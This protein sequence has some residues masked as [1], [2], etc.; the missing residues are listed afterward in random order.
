MVV[1]RRAA[2]QALAAGISLADDLA[3]WSLAGGRP[4]VAA[5]PG[6][7]DELGALLEAATGDA[8]RRRQ[9]AHYTPPA[10]AAELVAKAVGN[11]PAP[12]V[13]DPACGGGALLLAVARHLAAAGEAPADVLARLWGIDVDPVA[14]ATTEVALA[15]WAGTSPPPGH[16]VVG[17]G[18]LGDLAWPPVDVIVGNPPFLSQLGAA[19]AHR[20]VDRRR[21]RDH[22]G[23]AAL[24]YTDVAG[25]FLARACELVVPG[26]VVA[27]LQPQS[28]LGARDAAGVRAAVSA[29]G[30]VVDVWFPPPRAFAAAVE[31]CVPIVGVG[32]P[33][34]TAEW[35]PWLARAHGVPEVDLA[36]AGCLADEAT[37]TA[38][39]RGEYYGLVEQLHEAADLP[40]GRPIVTA[41][42]VDLGGCAWGERPARLGRRTWD[43]PVVDV[44]ALSGRAAAWVER[45]GVPKLVVASQTSVL[46]VA[47]DEHGAWI[48][49]VP[50][51]AVLAPPARLW[52][53]AAALASP[54]VSAWLLER[55]AGTALAPQALKASAPLL[56]Q[57]PLPTDPAAWQEGT[58]AF[59]ASDLDGFAAAMGRAYGVDASVGRWWEARAKRVWSR[60]EGPR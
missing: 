48:P 54:A 3:V 36:G 56:R 38:A 6:E 17:D 26:G 39:F 55:T 22:F 1:A 45:T 30:R 50:L 10:L 20:A 15:L 18:L 52:P 5:V 19:T 13:A 29:L 14:A 11:R 49:G 41:G 24:A 37:V 53:L 40:S 8:D 27:M 21:V 31:V 43:R 44:D 35:S 42:L 7:P 23:E 57:V 58:A 34:P 16:I 9:G 47:V 60:A 46:E 2:E 59:R 4:E 25:L 51:V 32:A 33:G 12:V 28:V